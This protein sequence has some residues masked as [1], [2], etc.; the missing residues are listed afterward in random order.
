MKFPYPDIFGYEYVPMTAGLV[1]CNTCGAVVPSN[2][3]DMHGAFHE[4]LR[5]R[6]KDAT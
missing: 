3:V 6:A 1:V 5:L 4:N 2:K